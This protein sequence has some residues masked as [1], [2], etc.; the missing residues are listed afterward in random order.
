MQGGN[1]KGEIAILETITASGLE[2]PGHR[3]RC[4]KDGAV[5]QRGSIP[6]CIV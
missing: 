2:L 6:D 3:G 1:Q 4:L 5:S